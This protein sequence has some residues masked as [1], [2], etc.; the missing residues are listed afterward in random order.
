MSLVTNK[1]MRR[2]QVS[3]RIG[4]VEMTGQSY[5][6]QLKHH[7]QLSAHTLAKPVCNDNNATWTA[8]H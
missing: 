6:M 7:P 8:L 3:L 2:I 1:Q 4:G 5:R